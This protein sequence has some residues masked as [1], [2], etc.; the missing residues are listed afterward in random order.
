MPAQRLSEIAQQFLRLGLIAYGGPAAHVAMMEQ[1]F[2][3]KR[4]W[5]SRQH[6]LDLL[7]ATNLIPG[8]NSTEM[9]MHLGY[10]RG[11]WKGLL[12]AGV[13]FV[14]PAALMTAA[15]AWFYVRYG[16]LPALQ[17]LLAGIK[18]AVVAVIVGA[19]WKLGKKAVKGRRYVPIVA[20][21]MLSIALG[22]G[23]IAALF[24]GGF[25]G[26]VWLRLSSPTG[27]A[28]AGLGIA[29]IFKGIPDVALAAAQGAASPT[30]PTLLKLGLFFLKIGAIL[31][32]SGYV[33]IA[34]L[35]GGLVEQ[36]GWLSEA[37][38]LDAVAVGQFTPG[39]V[40]TTSTFIGYVI[41]GPAGAAVATLG[42]F[43]PS[44]VFVGV[45]NPLIPKLR[46]SEWAA[47]FLDAINA[48]AVSLMAVV[49]LQLGRSALINWQAGVIAAAAALALH[50]N[51]NTAW[52][53]LGGAL[54]GW[55][56]G[57]GG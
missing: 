53:V 56:L 57:V 49:T 37:Q 18:P 14:T 40:L 20:V 31:Y 44:F 12:V 38:L 52:L 19:L 54:L 6:F 24:L 51:V 5:V 50:F 30:S 4:R 32:G 28:A 13:C 7:G 48:A 26:M 43:L 9:T 42:I 35:Q 41:A 29:A 15:L 11:G 25:A 22:M 36:Y 23:E 10:E 45:L 47:A 46:Q 21:V 33:L 2:V 17:P 55:A 3:E 34:F 39:P 8:P 27:A 16:A 1:E